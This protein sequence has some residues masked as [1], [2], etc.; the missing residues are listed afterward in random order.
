MIHFVVIA[1][2]EGKT[3]EQC[4]QWVDGQERCLNEFRKEY[5]SL[6]FTRQCFQIPSVSKLPSVRD[7]YHK[8][9]DMLGDAIGQSR[10]SDR[11]VAILDSR[12]WRSLGQIRSLRDVQGLLILAF[13]DV[14]WVPVFDDGK[15]SKDELKRALNLVAGGFNPLFD[16]TGVRGALLKKHKTNSAY[17]YDRD[18]VAVTIDEER[19]FAELTA[20]TAFRFGYRAYPVSTARLAEQVLGVASPEQ[21]PS[22]AGATVRQD[23]S[24]VV[25]EDRDVEFPDVDQTQNEKHILG[26]GREGKWPLLDKAR[27]RVLAT[28][29]EAEEAIGGV[30]N[31]A[32]QTDNGGAQGKMRGAT[33]DECFQNAGVKNIGGGQG[34]AFHRFL[35]KMQR[36]AFNL[37]AGW[38][39][40]VWAWN[41]FKCLLMGGMLVWVLIRCPILLIPSLF[42]LVAAFGF[43]R[44]AIARSLLFL[45]GHHERI[46]TFFN[47]R[48]QWRFYPKLYPS[49]FPWR[50]IQ[51][52]GTRY[53]CHVRKPFGGMFGLRNQCGL[54]NGSS[55]NGP[56]NKQTVSDIYRNALRG[57]APTKTGH[58]VEQPKHSAYGMTLDLATDL[59]GRSR[60]LK[61]RGQG[62]ENAIHA[63][64][65]ATCAYELLGHQTPALSI[66]ALELRHCCEVLAECEFPGVRA[67]QDMEDRLVD[68][69][70]SMWQIC[71]ARDG[72][73]RAEMFANGVASIC[74]KLTDILRS[75]GR[76]GEAAFLTRR[77]RHMHRLLLPPVMR[78]LLAY[79][80]WVLRSPWHFALSFS[81][82]ALVF[83]LYWVWGIERGCTL[84]HAFAK[85]YEVL[86]C[87]EPDLSWPG[88]QEASWVAVNGPFQAEAGKGNPNIWE[89]QP[90]EIPDHVKSAREAETRANA[91]K[92]KTPNRISKE[93]FTILVHT[94]RQLAL[95]HLAFLGLCFWDLMQRK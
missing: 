8:I 23:A 90:T 21:L 27:L 87:D 15:E 77:S 89:V 91:P 31:S 44:N 84:G 25:F 65:L 69:H 10:P 49:H 70:N 75:R 63:A 5:P 82:I 55:F 17:Q 38:M 46:R 85:T 67:R 53:W 71:R 79:P 81:A 76:Y 34:E 20:Y 26:G 4:R 68:I 9:A 83:C 93:T 36:K 60:V 95:L 64:V 32:W 80:E 58:D 12:S 22:L 42:L 29:A 19:H 66:E 92:K 7:A 86:V 3:P 56:L 28:V 1:D 24:L 57:L 13:P 18:D 62:I 35:G 59:I 14:L 54:P 30:D 39:G 45:F 61:D 52:E 72:S 51:R 2:A 40:D 37:F 48:S 78:N 73:V 50:Q 43:F 6:A 94:M 16:G 41:I 33:A 88:P 11:F 74:D 47:I